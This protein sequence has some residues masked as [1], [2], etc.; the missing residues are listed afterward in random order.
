[1][2]S[3]LRVFGAPILALSLLIGL[4]SPVLATDG[5]GPANHR[6][7]GTIRWRLE[8]P[9]SP[10]VFWRVVDPPE[11]PVRITRLTL[12]MPQRSSSSASPLAL[13]ARPMPSWVWF[14]CSSRSSL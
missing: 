6:F 3:Y 2:R 11:R 4:G 8:S 5:W 9:F 12:S 13:P 14:G 1:M 10:V 7:W